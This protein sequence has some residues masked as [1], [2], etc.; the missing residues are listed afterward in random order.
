LAKEDGFVFEALNFT[1]ACP[2]HLLNL[3]EMKGD[4][5]KFGGR[6]GDGIVASVDHR[7]QMIVRPAWDVTGGI[8]TLMQRVRSVFKR[9]PYSW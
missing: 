9:E 7:N 2:K 4:Q 3:V 1:V 5:L 8:A 6:R